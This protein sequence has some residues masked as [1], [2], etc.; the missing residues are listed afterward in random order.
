MRP[1]LIIPLLLQR[2]VSADDLPA[3]VVER[4]A[5]LPGGMIAL[6]ADAGYEH[7]RVLDVIVQHDAGLVLAAQWGVTDRWELALATPIVVQPD[8]RWS[9]EGVARVTYR[10]WSRA[11][12]ELAPLATVPLSAHSG[13]DI[14]STIVLGANVRW[15]AQDRMLI[16][17]G[18]QLIPIAIRP[19]AALDL[20]LDGGIVLQL[21]DRWAALAQLA[22]GEL[23]LV[24]QID[25]SVAPWHHLMSSAGA[26]YATAH[27]LDVAVELHGD[28]LHPRDRLGVAVT[29]T[30]RL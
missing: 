30:R 10:A 20:G 26:L 6:S 2:S 25:R 27:Q 28:A 11:S 5:T 4:P 21:G 3:A 12:L 9:R 7:A 24:G 16:V 15:R 8:A 22:V 19:A 14:N 1:L 17:L 23:T 29:V 18:R 13:A